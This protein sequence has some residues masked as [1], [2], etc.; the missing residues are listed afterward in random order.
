MAES[1]EWLKLIGMEIVSICQGHYHITIFVEKYVFFHFSL[2]F[3]PSVRYT[4]TSLIIGGSL[5]GI[6]SYGCLQISAQRFLCV[7]S[8]RSAKFVAW[9]SCGFLI[10][11]LLLSSLVAFNIYAKYNEC[12]PIK[13]KLISKA[14]QVWNQ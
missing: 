8:M 6:S 2:S 5:Y 9:L 7:K 4:Y 3:N 11:T 13:A 10:L 1:P 14:D 12:D